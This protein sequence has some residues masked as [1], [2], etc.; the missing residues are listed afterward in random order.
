MY[1]ADNFL[2][3]NNHGPALLLLDY[4]ASSIILVFLL[5]IGGAYSCLYRLSLRFSTIYFPLL[6]VKS[7]RSSI[8]TFFTFGVSVCEN[9]LDKS[10]GWIFIRNI[11]TKIKSSLKVDHSKTA[12]SIFNGSLDTLFFTLTHNMPLYL[13][14]IP[15]AFRFHL[16]PHVEVNT[17]LPFLVFL[18]ATFQV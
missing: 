16:K 6:H 10:I 11:H 2:E 15:S 18:G 1:N 9:A 3:I 5:H 8:Y 14:I 17:S 12:A 7:V 13:H 4:L